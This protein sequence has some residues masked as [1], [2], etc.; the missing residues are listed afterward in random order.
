MSVCLLI[1]LSDHMA[2][3]LTTRMAQAVIT[4]RKLIRPIFDM[5]MT[6]RPEFA[7]GANGARTARRDRNDPAAPGR[8]A[9]VGRGRKCQ[10]LMTSA[11]F[12]DGPSP[13]DRGRCGVAEGT[14]VPEALHHLAFA[15]SGHVRRLHFQGIPVPSDVEELALFLRQLARSRQEPPLVAVASERRHYSRMPDQLLITKGEAAERLGVSV[16]TVER[17][18][19]TGLPQVHVERSARFRVKDLESYVEGLPESRPDDIDHEDEEAE[20][21]VSDVLAARIRAPRRDSDV[22]RA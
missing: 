11:K 9:A 6:T 8:Q 1:V 17:L 2:L 15:L 13:P 20:A 7:K 12:Q 14:G 18:V 4:T 22:A 16:R 19:A 21:D 10:S 5:P 3:S